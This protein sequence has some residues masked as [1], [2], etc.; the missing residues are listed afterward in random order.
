[1]KSKIFKTTLGLFLLVTALEGCAKHLSLPQVESSPSNPS[2]GLV[3]NS[4]EAIETSIYTQINQHR[5]SLNLTLIRLDPFLSE[6]ARLYSQQVAQGQTS[7]E[8][9]NFESQFEQISKQIPFESI[10]INLAYNEGYDDPATTTVENWLESSS[11]R[12]NIEGNFDL[13]GIGVAKNQANEYYF[14]QILLEEVPSISSSNLRELELE[15]FRQVNEYRQSRGLSTLR[16]DER[17]SQQSRFHS[18]AMAQGSA[19]FSHDG[20][21]QRIDIISNSIS[22]RGAAE[23]LAYNQGYDD[24]VKVA[25]EGWINSPGHHKNMI[26]DFDLTGVGVARNDQGEYYMNQI[27]IKQ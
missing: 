11:H 25:V 14:T 4:T 6:Q 20:F 16:L 17:I 26:G 1:M 5:Q 24:P 7:F 23:N 13:M 12:Q 19:T 8:N 9:T 2:V 22:Y 10:K 3:S 18:E 15:V 27:F 21:D